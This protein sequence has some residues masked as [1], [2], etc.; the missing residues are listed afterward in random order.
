MTGAGLDQSRPESRHVV[1]QGHPVVDRGQDRATGGEK[2][3]QNR[4]IG[5]AADRAIDDGAHE[6]ESLDAQAQDE[7]TNG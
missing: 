1:G 4:A 6:A 5:A 7:T 3:D 2:A